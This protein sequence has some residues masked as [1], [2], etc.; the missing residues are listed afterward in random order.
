MLPGGLSTKYPSSLAARR[1]KA[2]NG[3]PTAPAQQ[4]PRPLRVKERKACPMAALATGG[5]TN[6]RATKTYPYDPTAGYS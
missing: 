6:A 5:R 4:T 3:H 2:L 1:N